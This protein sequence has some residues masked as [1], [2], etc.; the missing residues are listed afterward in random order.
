[1]KEAHSRQE[2]L[3]ALADKCQSVART[4]SYNDNP[5]EASAKHVLREASHALDTCVVHVYKCKSTKKMMIANARGK[6]R[7]MT[8]RERFAYYLLGTTEVLV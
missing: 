6:E 3:S 2:F 1:M 4:L 7:E 8:W 5:S